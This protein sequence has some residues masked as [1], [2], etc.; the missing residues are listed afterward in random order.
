VRCVEVFLVA[1]SFDAASHSFRSFLQ[2]FDLE[3]AAVLQRHNVD[4]VLCIGFMRV[5][6]SALLDQFRWRMLNVHPS[7][8]P[9]F[10][11]GMDLSVHQVRARTGVQHRVFRRHVALMHLQIVSSQAVLDARVP[12]TGCTVHFVEE[13]VDAGAILLQKS[14]SVSPGDTA[15]LLK[16]RV[17]V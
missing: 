2:V 11:G 10:A 17:Q 16:A 15:E 7:L 13:A 1:L 8:L 6:T 9:A 5:M 4:V 12:V 14:C 3:V